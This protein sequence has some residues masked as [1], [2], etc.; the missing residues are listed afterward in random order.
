MNA[1]DCDSGDSRKCLYQPAPRRYI[2]VAIVKLILQFGFA[3]R[4][5]LIV[6]L[7]KLTHGTSVALLDSFAHA[8]ELKSA[9]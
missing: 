3:D 5:S 7:D 4:M 1:D 9:Y 2:V 8:G 6:G